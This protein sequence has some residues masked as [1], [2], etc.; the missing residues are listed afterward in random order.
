MGRKQG[1]MTMTKRSDLF[2][3]F[4]RNGD[5][6]RADDGRTRFAYGEACALA[7]RLGGRVVK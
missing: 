2:R 3:V 6:Y 5:L 7:R 4:D 1:T